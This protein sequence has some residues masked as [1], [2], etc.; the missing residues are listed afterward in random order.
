MAKGQLPVFV[1]VIGT[2]S[3]PLVYVSPPAVF[4]L[5][6]NRRASTVTTWPRNLEDLQPVLLSKSL[7]TPEL[8]R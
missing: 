6:Q 5:Q 1:N 7:L 8:N 3:G 2:Q 4:M